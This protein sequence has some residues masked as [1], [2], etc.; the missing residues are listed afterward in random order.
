[1]SHSTTYCLTHPGDLTCTAAAV[2]FNVYFTTVHV[3]L[4]TNHC[5]TFADFGVLIN[6]AWLLLNTV[7]FYL[8][9]TFNK[10]HIYAVGYLI[11]A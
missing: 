8:P 10:S 11:C 5:Q 3:Q 4:L 2:S 1:M 9:S 7:V 6:C